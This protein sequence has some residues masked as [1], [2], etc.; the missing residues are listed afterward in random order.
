MEWLDNHWLLGHAFY[1]CTI[2]KLELGR[3]FFEDDSSSFVDLA[4]NLL[5]LT[6][7]MGG[8]YVKNRTVALLDDARM[9]HDDHLGSEPFCVLSRVVISVGCHI[10]SFDF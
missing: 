1:H 9:V 2:S 10:A 3:E 8:V 6:C 7:N 4:L 5:E